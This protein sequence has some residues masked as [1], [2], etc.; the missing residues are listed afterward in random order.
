MVS[1]SHDTRKQNWVRKKAE[2]KNCGYYVLC[3]IRR[4][5][6]HKVGLD[7]SD[8]YG[9]DLYAGELKYND[10]KNRANYLRAVINSLRIGKNEPDFKKDIIG[11][12]PTD[13]L[14]ERSQMLVRDLMN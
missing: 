9:F 1:C 2:V 12:A 11:I 5:S 10:D 6:L 14:D 7:N 3:L 13:E 4:T 8:C